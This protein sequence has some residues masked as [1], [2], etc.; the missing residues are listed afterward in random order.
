MLF[1]NC[2]FASVMTQGMKDKTK[3]IPINHCQTSFL[4]D[5]PIFWVSLEHLLKKVSI[6][7]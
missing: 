3:L 4:K 2:Y 1:T 6:V 7:M 5:A